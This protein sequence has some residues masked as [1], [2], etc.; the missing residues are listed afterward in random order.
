[1]GNVS[2]VRAGVLPC[3]TANITDGYRFVYS[4]NMSILLIGSSHIKRFEHYI[5][6]KDTLSNFQLP[7]VTE[8]HF[9]GISGGKINNANHVHIFEQA[10]IE[11]KPSGVLVQIGGNDLD[12]PG[13]TSADAHLNCWPCILC[14]IVIYFNLYSKEYLPNQPCP[15]KSQLS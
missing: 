4:V 5:D 8:V 7:K 3:P 12:K 9:K 13:V 2:F 1:M 6:R 11:H 14:Q 15:M 10:I